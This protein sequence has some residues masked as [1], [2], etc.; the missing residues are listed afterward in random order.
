MLG[1][2]LTKN[3]RMYSDREA[4]VYEDK[5]E[6]YRELNNRFNIFAPKVKTVIESSPKVWGNAVIVFHINFGVKLWLQLWFLNQEKKQP[7]RK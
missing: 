2:L 3:A 7:K 1:L 4:L 6:T 5:R